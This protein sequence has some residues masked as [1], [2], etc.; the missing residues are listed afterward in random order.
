MGVRTIFSTMKAAV[1]RYSVS[2]Y[3]R[4]Q[5]HDASSGTIITNDTM[6]SVIIASYG[7]FG[8]LARTLTS[9]AKQRPDTA[10]E[11]IV[12]DSS[13]DD[14]IQEI[15]GRFPGMRL[16]SLS[17]R[18]YPGEARNVG[19]REARGDLLVF[20]DADCSVPNDWIVNIRAL[21]Q[22]GHRIVGGTVEN[23]NPERFFG[24]VY[25]FCKFHLWTSGE[26]IRFVSEIP[27]T[28][29]S[30]DREIFDRY[31]PFAEGCYSSDSVFQ[32]RSSK[33]EG[34]ALLSP[35]IGVQHLN[36]WRVSKV[37]AKLYQHG[38][39]FATNRASESQWPQLRALIY[40]SGASVLPVVL[41]GKI[42][43]NI[44]RQRRHSLRFLLMT[45]FV[46]LGLTAWSLGEAVGYLRFVRLRNGR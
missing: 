5:H 29:L 19:V 30:L 37:L 20:T 24:W 14:R 38:R 7:A 25:Y 34:D 16:I 32:W 26:S 46:L 4:A 28:C 45:P 8:T 39:D 22:E 35:A 11:V 2:S 43:R 42:A 17:G 44:L 9:L 10:F 41:F 15:V 36:Y 40:A 21:H 33:E 13:E 18:R 3:G 31:G 27:T 23:G 12:V 1:P 6:V